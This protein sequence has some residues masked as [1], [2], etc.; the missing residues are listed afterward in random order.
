MHAGEYA[1][2]GLLLARALRRRERGAPSGA[3]GALAVVLGAAYGASDEYHQTFVPGRSGN[4]PG[5][6]LA[7]TIGTTAGVLLYARLVQRYKD[8]PWL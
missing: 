8:R 1:G 2:L 5:D 7:D 3:M 4:D 6:W